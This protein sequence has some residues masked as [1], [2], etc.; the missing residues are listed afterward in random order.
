[1]PIFATPKPIGA[2][3]QVAGAHVRVTASDRTDTVVLIQPRNPASRTDVKVAD[4]TKVDFTGGRL[5]VKTTVSGSKEGSVLISIDLPSGSDLVAYLG[6]S[7]V[8]ADGPLGGCELHVAKGRARLECVAALQANVA[9]GEV[10]IDRIAGGATVEGSQV[11]LQI[12]EAGGPVGLQSSGGRTWIGHARAELDLCSGSGSVHIGRAD[13]S[14]I[15]RT[16][17][18]S[19][20]IGRL[21]RGRA[22][23]MNGSEDIEIGISE[24]TTARIDAKSTRGSVRDLVTAQRDPGPSGDEVVVHARTRHGDIVIHRTAS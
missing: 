14:V 3:L 8:H 24:H 9:D 18:G 21:T 1:M 15:T 22:E 16:G 10:A 20:R 13:A 23:L 12:N 17:A 7:D 11:E 5:S 6:H 4:R 2:T 19:I